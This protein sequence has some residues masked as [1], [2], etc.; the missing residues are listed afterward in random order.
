MEKNHPRT[1]TGTRPP[2]PLHPFPCLL[3]DDGVPFPDSVVNPSGSILLSIPQRRQ[4]EQR[5]RA[6]NWLLQNIAQ[7]LD[8]IITNTRHCS[9]LTCSSIKACADE[10]QRSRRYEERCCIDQ[11]QQS[12]AFNAIHMLEAYFIREQCSKHM[13]S[14]G[15]LRRA[16]QKERT[17]RTR[18][19]IWPGRELVALHCCHRLDQFFVEFLFFFLFQSNLEGFACTHIVEA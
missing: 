17:P 11:Q 14:G 18:A 1:R 6:Q 13:K 16:N 12:M 7:S 2:H 10:Q 19:R 8:N 3:Q 9:L 15:H 5:Y 4:Q